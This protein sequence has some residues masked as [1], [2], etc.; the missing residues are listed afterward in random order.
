LQRLS[1]IATLTHQFVE[2]VKGTRA[3]IL[4]T[5]KTTPG[6]RRL[7]KYAVRVGG[8]ENHRLG[9]YDMILIKENHIV[10]A[11][12][13]TAAVNLVRKGLQAMNLNLK[14]E[15]ETRTIPEVEEA[16]LAKV[17]RIMLDNMN[18]K[19]IREAVNIVKGA[20]ELEV[21]GGVS[22]ETVGEI[23][24]TGVDYISVGAL[25]HSAKALDL[26]LLVDS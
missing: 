3:K 24:G 22:L 15:V 26:S 2:R 17:D 13:I 11:G 14:I 7:E 18:L 19:Q 1:G 10:A 25:T 5:R 9:L 8:G 4:D 20:V 16:L 12:G 23:A 6:W 21:S